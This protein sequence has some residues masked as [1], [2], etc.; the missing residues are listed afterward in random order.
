MRLDIPKDPEARWLLLDTDI[1]YEGEPVDRIV[2]PGPIGAL[3]NANVG[4]AS[5]V[6]VRRSDAKVLTLYRGFV[7][8]D[9]G[10][11]RDA[12]GGDAFNIPVRRDRI[13]AISRK[14]HMLQARCDF[15][16][17]RQIWKY[18]SLP[19]RPGIVDRVTFDAVGVR[20]LFSSHGARRLKLPTLLALL[21]YAGDWR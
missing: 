3:N 5:V 1:R 15:E 7:K 14:R 13:R 18:P 12:A 20:M 2:G 10:T 11:H 6:L 4:L 17:E 19:A 8:T 21:D 16:A 9:W